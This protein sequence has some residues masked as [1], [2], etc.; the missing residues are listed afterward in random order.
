MEPAVCSVVNFLSVEFSSGRLGASLLCSGSD[1][2][3]ASEGKQLHCACHLSA[4]GARIF[5]SEKLCI[6]TE[7]TFHTRPWYLS[8]RL[9]DVTSQVTV[10]L[11]S[12]EAIK[13]RVE[14]R[15]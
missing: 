3:L 4:S 1:T 13:P 9:Y 14:K 5:A 12:I 2:G 15:L 6:N 11:I 8:T 10:F 7:K